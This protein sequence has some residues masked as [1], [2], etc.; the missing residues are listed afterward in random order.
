MFGPS[1][2]GDK[3]SPPTN[4]DFYGFYEFSRVSVF[5]ESGLNRR[6]TSISAGA[7]PLNQT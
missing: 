6:L 1:L 5:A 2:V 3:P 4:F 7:R